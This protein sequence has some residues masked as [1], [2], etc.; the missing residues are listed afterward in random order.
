MIKLF[1]MGMRKYLL[2]VISFSFI[3]CSQTF[4]VVR[5]AE[6]EKPAQGMSSDVALSVQGKKRAEDLTTILKNKNI[7]TIFSTNTIRTKSTAEP[8]AMFRSISIT[9]YESR[10]DSFFVKKVK[11]SKGNV[12]VVGHSNTVDEIVNMLCDEIVIPANLPDESYD[13]LFVVKRK[14]I[15]M[16]FENK[17][18][19]DSNY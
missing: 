19:G 4:Y 11:D 18:Y 14:G 8:L 2:V 10:P 6:K 12:L 3:S 15:K 9:L 17:K 13:N 16:K 7:S 5:H 1:K